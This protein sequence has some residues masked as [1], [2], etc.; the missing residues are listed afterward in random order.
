VEV[1]ASAGIYGGYPG[2]TYQS[3]I[4]RNTNIEELFR[5]GRIPENLD[6]LQGKLEVLPI[7]STTHWN[8][9]DL[10]AGT[11]PGGGGYG[12]PLD[13]DPILVARDAVEGLVS[14]QCAHEIYGVV[15]DPDL[16]LLETKT[17]QKRRRL[18]KRRIMRTHRGSN[19]SS[20]DVNS[21]KR[22]S[23]YLEITALGEKSVIRC[24]KCK[25]TFCASN[26]NYKNYASVKKYLLSKGGPQ[27]NP[28]KMSKRFEL[29]HFCCPGCGVLLEVDVSLKDDPYLWDLQLE[30]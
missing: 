20:F 28:Y 11:S 14:P 17:E 12:D 24:R 3:A 29:R 16:Q 4:K 19:T 30:M 18:R 6:E 21:A 10:L 8:Q 2:S 9:G 13:R 26:D 23:E 5:N 25:F 7:M 22:A 27:I 1:P 15:L